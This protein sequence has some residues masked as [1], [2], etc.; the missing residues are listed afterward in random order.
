MMQVWHDHFSMSNSISVN[1]F[2]CRLLSSCCF[3]TVCLICKYKN[4][5]ELQNECR[6][7]RSPPGGIIDGVKLLFQMPLSFIAHSN[8]NFI[9]NQVTFSRLLVSENASSIQETN[10]EI[11]RQVWQTWKK[12]TIKTKDI[13]HIP[14]YFRPHISASIEIFER[15]TQNESSRVKS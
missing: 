7:S 10:T 12:T 11:S 1:T 13:P 6:F 5:Y 3:A 9:W 2:I 14:Q 4:N 8:P 15:V